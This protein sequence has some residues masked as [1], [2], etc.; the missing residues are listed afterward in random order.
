MATP[1]TKPMKIS[2]SRFPVPPTPPWGLPTPRSQFRTTTCYHPR[3]PAVACSTIS[4]ARRWPRYDGNNLAINALDDNAIATDKTAYLWE[5][6]GAATFA[7]VSSYTKG[8]NGIM[9]DISGS[10]PNITA[11]DFIFRVGNNNS[12]HLWST[13]NAPTSVSVRAGA[14]V[15]GSDRVT[16]IWNTGAPIKQWLEVI[17]LA[18][19]DTGLAQKAGHPAGHGDAFFFGNAVGNSGL[20]DTAINATVNATDENGARL[21]PAN[22]FANIPITNIYDYDRNAQV[23]ANDQNAARLNA[24]NLATVVKIPELDQ[25]AGGTGIGPRRRRGRRGRGWCPVH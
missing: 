5:D 25:L 15:G 21:N 18:N 3:L 23:N 24:T 11:D 1:P 10:H 16:I 9:V 17:V 20:G 4:R 7:N 14:G 13:A 12:P 22:L 6:A 2:L 8:I 19:A